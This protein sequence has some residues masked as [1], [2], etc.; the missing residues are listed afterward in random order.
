MKKKE[1]KEKKRKKREQ[2]RKRKTTSVLPS[3]PSC[4]GGI[5]FCVCVCVCVCNINKQNRKYLPCLVNSHPHET[6][7]QIITSPR[8]TLVSS[9]NILVLLKFYYFYGL[10]KVLLFLWSY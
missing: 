3:L 5:C 9:F 6:K 7:T 2:E 1:R 10:I 8:P 4:L